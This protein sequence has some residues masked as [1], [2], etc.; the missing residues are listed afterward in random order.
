M[1]SGFW[2]GA[3]FRLVAVGLAIGTVSDGRTSRVTY[4]QGVTDPT[5]VQ[6]R[7]AIGR[8]RYAEAEAL[9]KPVAAKTPDGEAALELGL[10]YEMLGRRDEARGARP[11]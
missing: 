2:R 11:H 1:T 5:V 8:G 7:A 6:A 9:L 10:F 3:L 4:A